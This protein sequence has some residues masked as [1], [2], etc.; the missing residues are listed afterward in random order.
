MGAT[1]SADAFAKS[2]LQS[3]EVDDLKTLAFHESD[4]S[5]PAWLP[6]AYAGALTL[7]MIQRDRD[8]LRFPS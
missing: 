6:P 3:S 8:A 2:T 7:K 1:Q 4:F 5:D